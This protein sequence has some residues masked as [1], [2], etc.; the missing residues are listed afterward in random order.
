MPRILNGVDPYSIPDIEVLDGKAV[1][2]AAKFSAMNP[3]NLT[4][5]ELQDAAQA[6]R[7]A[8]VQAEADA[9]KQSSPRVKS[10]FDS[11]A[12]RWRELAEKFERARIRSG[13]RG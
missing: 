13:I 11:S 10:M 3:L 1:F 8:S 2:P 9:E 4:D 7:I 5:D 6:A 12:R